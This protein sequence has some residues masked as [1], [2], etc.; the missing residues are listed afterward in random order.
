MLHVILGGTFDPVHNG[1]LRMA[2]ELHEMFDGAQLHLMP[3]HRPPHREQPGACATD[4]LAMLNAGMEGEAG[5]SVDERELREDRV[6]YTA[7]SLRQ[8]RH[9]YGE[10]VPLAIVVGTDAFNHFDQWREWMQIPRLA[11]IIVVRRPGFPLL[12]S[13][14]AAALLEQREVA[15]PGALL[16]AASGGILS[17][18]LRLLEVSATDI[19]RRVGEGLSTRY[20]V[21]DSVWRYI[22]NEGLY[23]ADLQ[24]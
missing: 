6:S 15:S 1:H 3:C 11:H 12:P 24:G 17:L 2:V 20:L 16:A 4:R 14:A 19:R 10:S 23:M 21:P 22:R 9:E 13:E 5:L 7:E 18:E 8:L